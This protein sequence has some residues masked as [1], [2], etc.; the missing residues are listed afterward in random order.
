MSYNG[1]KASFPLG[2]SGLIGEPNTPNLPA[3]ALID[4]DNI[5]FE[6]GGISKEG[7][8]TK[9][10]ST[11]LG[12]VSI[13]GGVDWFLDALT[14]RQVVYTSDGK[15]Q[16]TTSG[17]SFTVLKSS[18]SLVPT[19]PVF[20]CGGAE[21]ATNNRKLFC[22]NGV[23]NVQV[24]SGDGATTSDLTTPPSDWSTVKPTFGFIHEGRLWAGA[25]HRLYYSRAADHEDFTGAG[26]G[27]VPV[28]TG[29]GQKVIGGYGFKGGAL[30][31]KYP[32]GI[33]LID[34]SSVTVA[35]WRVTE[36]N[37][38]I[39]M[40][41]PLAFAQLEDDVI[42]QDSSGSYYL[43]S[44]VQALGSVEGR[45][46]DYQLRLRKFISDRI[47]LSRLD[48][49]IAIYYSHK[50]EVH[51]ACSA[52]GAVTNNRRLVFDFNIG[53][54]R[55]RLSSKDVCEGLW[56]TNVA[57]VR[58]PYCGDEAG[59]IWQ[60]DQANKNKDGSGYS[61]FFQT[62]F[63]DFARYGEELATR[64]KWSTFLESQVFPTGNYNLALIPIWDGRRSA[65]IQFNLGQEGASLG[66]FL[67]GT[68]MLSGTAMEG[69]V[70][71]MVSGGKRFSFIVQNN[72]ANQDYNVSKMFLYYTVGDERVS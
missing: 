60:L 37:T 14:Q 65:A 44:A 21:A 45:S 66:S 35:E 3:G 71:S 8:S 58:K 69:R 34:T 72:A 64:V 23:N 41:S 13:L 15:L 25:G 22:F 48:K 61:S 32:T 2:L 57:G 38:G 49:V 28:A 67:L 29:V 46:I 39:G 5:T 19:L 36:V 70:R 11:T 52:V 17:S 59:F 9:L 10:N 31:F 43:L 16:K 6:T 51:F 4:C 42:F 27:V 18:L 24:L 1:A 30:I 54:I 12:A 40:S 33:Y 7:G 20:V 55:V 50:K 53:S 26:S 56:L 68:D 63:D 62:A 47:N